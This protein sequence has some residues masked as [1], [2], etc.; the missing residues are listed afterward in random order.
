[1][2]SKPVF[3]KNLFE[4]LICLL[5]QLFLQMLNIGEYK[6]VHNYKNRIFFVAD[7][8]ATKKIIANVVSNI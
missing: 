2:F 8:K 7:Q 6:Y 5:S 3:K 1:M 4:I